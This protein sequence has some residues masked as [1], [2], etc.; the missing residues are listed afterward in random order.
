ML[1]SWRAN[2]NQSQ[3]VLELFSSLCTISFIKKTLLKRV[4]KTPNVLISLLAQLLTGQKCYLI[5][6]FVPWTHLSLLY[7]D[8]SSGGGQFI[9]RLRGLDESERWNSWQTTIRTLCLSVPSKG[10]R[11]NGA[12]LPSQQLNWTWRSRHPVTLDFTQITFF[13]QKTLS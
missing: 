5:D 11:P 2:A 7:T 13:Q 1:A 3:C 6:V 8:P 10:R 4:N 12:N 9:L